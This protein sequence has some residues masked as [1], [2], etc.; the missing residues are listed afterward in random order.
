MITMITMTA[1]TTIT[2]SVRMFLYFEVSRCR[3][4]RY[5]KNVIL[6]LLLLPSGTRRLIEMMFFISNTVSMT[7]QCAV[8]KRM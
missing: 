5:L 1:M 4:K 8:L 3:E 6:L 7:S 2:N